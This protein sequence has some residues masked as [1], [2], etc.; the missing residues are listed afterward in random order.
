[1]A[2]TEE[3]AP[4]DWNQMIIKEFRENGGK[5]GGQFEGATLALLTFT[6]RKSGTPRTTPV[7]YMA[8][9]DRVV[10]F[11]TNAGAPKH[12]DW[13]LNVIAEPA[14]TVEIGTETYPATAVPVE[15]AERDRLFAAAELLAPVFT[16]YQAKIERTIPAVAV[17]RVPSR[18]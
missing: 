5:V 14:V 2:D 7:W 12:P 17:Y 16:E 11:G 3:N 10:V 9:G 13:Y 15:G 1:M 8:D 18:R 6:G 4:V